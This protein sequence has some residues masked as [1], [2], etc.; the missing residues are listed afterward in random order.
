MIGTFN[1]KNNTISINKSLFLHITL[2]WI[3]LTYTDSFMMPFLALLW[4]HFTPILVMW[5]VF[6]NSN[7]E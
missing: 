2:K 4:Y 1:S 6:K 3:W 5:N 7:N